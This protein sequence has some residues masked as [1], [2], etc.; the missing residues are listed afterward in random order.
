MKGQERPWLKIL[1]K[2]IFLP[3]C[4][5]LLSCCKKSLH[6][7]EMSVPD[8]IGAPKRKAFFKVSDHA[9]CFLGGQLDSWMALQKAKV[10]TRVLP[11]HT[12]AWSQLRTCGH[13]LGVG[14][15]FS[16]HT[17]TSG[18]PSETCVVAVHVLC[19]LLLLVLLQPDGQTGSFCQNLG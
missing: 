5:Q 9:R 15:L 18:S 7:G 10:P 17:R 1:Q 12:L 3:P 16:E 13:C 19:F 8:V 4:S 11:T 6:S 2:K 14:C